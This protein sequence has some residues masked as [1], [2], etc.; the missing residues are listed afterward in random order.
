[1]RYAMLCGLLTV[2][3]GASVAKG[4][5]TGSL[6]ET[7]VLVREMT[8]RVVYHGA[9]VLAHAGNC[10]LHVDFE[11]PDASF[12]LPLKGT[13]VREIPSQDSIVVMNKDMTRAVRDKAPEPFGQLVLRLRRESLVPMLKL[14]EAIA[15]CSEEGSR[16]ATVR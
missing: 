12:D 15:A 14:F 10:R 8:A 16:V 4:Q 1:M 7:N 3:L 13:T 9:R 11:A 2:I 5:D 6:R